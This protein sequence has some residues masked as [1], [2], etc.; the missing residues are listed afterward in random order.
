MKVRAA[1]PEDAPALG[2]IHVATWRTAYRGLV[3]DERL[4]GLDPKRSAEMFERLIEEGDPKTFV[5]ARD[6]APLAFLTVGACRDED[7]EGK[8]GEIWGIYVTPEAWRQGIGRMLCL[9]GESILTEKGFASSALWVFAD[10]DDA[11]R[12]YEAMGYHVDGASKTLEI[13]KPLEAVRYVK[14]LS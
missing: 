11:R 3:P 10:N 1:V 12:F 9:H 14:S 2:A 4:D 6:D 13:G 5:A 8:A 7:L